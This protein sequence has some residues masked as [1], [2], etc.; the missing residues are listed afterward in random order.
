MEKPTPTPD[1]H[2]TAQNNTEDTVTLCR[3][4][5][6]SQHC[7]LYYKEFVS[8]MASRVGKQGS[9]ILFQVPCDGV[10]EDGQKCD[11]K[12]I[13]MIHYFYIE[14]EIVWL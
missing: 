14:S 10:S 7:T 3:R 11:I 2:E 9:R 6:N 12:D 13:L 1:H 5:Q 8:M 4:T